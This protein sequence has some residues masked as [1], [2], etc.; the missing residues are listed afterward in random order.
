METPTPYKPSDNFYNMMAKNFIWGA[1][2]LI[3]GIVV[4]NTVCFISNNLNM[5]N[6]L[7]QN[8]MQLLLCSFILAQIHI[9]YNE[10]GWTWQNVTPGL[11]F[12]SFFFGAQFN[13]FTNVQ[14]TYITSII[15]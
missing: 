10:F 7:L 15:K 8:I 2:G 6:L 11:F 3:L 13:I 1:L 4:N 5:K 12:V 14:S 9:H